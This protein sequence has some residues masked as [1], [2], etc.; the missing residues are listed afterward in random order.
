MFDFSATALLTP[1]TVALMGN[2]I[3]GLTDRAL[4]IGAMG[5]LMAVGLVLSAVWTLLGPLRLRANADGRVVGVASPDNAIVEFVTADG[6]TVRYVDSLDGGL[7]T[8]QSVPVRY[9]PRAAHRARV[10]TPDATYLTPLLMLAIAPV[11]LSATWTI[12]KR[13]NSV[14]PG[15]RLSVYI[16]LSASLDKL[17]PCARG[18][19][20]ATT[21]RRRLHSYD[22][23]RLAAAPF[24]STLVGAQIAA[25]QR[26]LASVRQGG[27]SLR[28]AP[29]EAVSQT[30]SRERQELIDAGN[31]RC[32]R[33][34]ERF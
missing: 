27:G 8:G 4:G 18:A 5:V 22:R 6:V 1:S 31:L 30:L 9:N 2:E 29:I 34:C 3:L 23:A 20:S 19:C 24:D 25:L 28:A 15:D 12:V 16:P 33:R 32:R 7:R 21:M 14:A 11:V 17:E 13:E 26:S 10:A